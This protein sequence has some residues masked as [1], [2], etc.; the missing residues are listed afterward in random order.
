MRV[1]RCVALSSAHTPTIDCADRSARFAV[2]LNRLRVA[3]YT[4]VRPAGCGRP[5]PNPSS[6]FPLAMRASQCLRRRGGGI[7]KF[8]R[9]T[10]SHRSP[11]VHRLWIPR[12][13][14]S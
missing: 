14:D 10:L 3:A 5:P 11:R 6:R 2:P 4:H 7:P 1:R 12:R 9:A 13:R 8:R